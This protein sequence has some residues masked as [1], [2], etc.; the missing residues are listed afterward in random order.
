[1]NH[2]FGPLPWVAYDFSSLEFD[3]IEVYNGSAAFDR[4]DAQ[5]IAYW[6]EQL[7]LGR[8]SIP[9]AASDCHRWDTPPPGDLLN[10]ALGWPHTQLGLYEGEDWIDGIRA[11]RVIL[12]DPSSSLMLT[13]ELNQ[14][15]FYPCMR[16]PK[17]SELRL[18]ASTQELDM[19]VELIRAGHGV[20][21]RE[22]LDTEKTIVQENIEAGIYYAKI[23][24]AT[25]RYGG[26]GIALTAPIFVE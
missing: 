8:Y 15:R 6:E 10:P 7:A 14:Q 13:A 11:G 16:A 19:V 3:G 22:T 1:M 23:M 25:E 4:S 26:R 21:E 9:I 18:A 2:P 5:A 17:G 24:P 20:L 12:G